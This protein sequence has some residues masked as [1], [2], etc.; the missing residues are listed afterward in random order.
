MKRESI[1]KIQTKKVPKNHG[2]KMVG[3]EEDCKR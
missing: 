1:F 2:S 3:K